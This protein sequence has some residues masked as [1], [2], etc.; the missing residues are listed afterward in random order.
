MKRL[1]NVQSIIFIAGGVLMVVSVAC[2]ILMWQQ[3]ITCWTFL[4]GAVMFAS[5]QV[6]QTYEGRN[7]AISRLKKIMGFA[8]LCF[9]MAGLLIVDSTYYYIA[10]LFTNWETYIEYVYNKWVLLL[11]VA[12]LLEMYATHRISSELKKEDY[13]TPDSSKP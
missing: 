13:N 5:M 11:L 4:I 12:A 3:H 6:M 9:V 1:T 10:S 2:Y 8:D 7:L